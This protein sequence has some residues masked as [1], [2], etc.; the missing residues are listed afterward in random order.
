MNSTPFWG[1]DFDQLAD[2]DPE[3]A[4]IILSE[5]DRLRGGL[6]LIA[7][8]NFTSPAVLAAL[9]S[10]LSNKYAEGYPG[11]R[12]YGGCADVDRAEIDR[13]RPGE[14]PVRR[15]PRQ[16]AAAQRGQREH[17]RL[18]R[19]RHA[20]RHGPGDEPAAR[21]PPH[22]RLEGQLL[23]QV[24]RHRVVRRPPGHRAHRLRRGARPR[25]PAPPEDDHHRCHGLPE[26]H[27][28]RRLP[29]D[30]RRGRRHPDGRRRPLHRPR[31]RPGD[32]QSGAVRRRRHLH[33]P[34]GP[35]RPARRHDPVQGGAR[36]GASTRPCSR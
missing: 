8:E 3:I 2:E 15:R 21:R 6:Q 27:R 33:H 4:S 35:A 1:P 16:P 28:L 24:V 19:L 20:G 31:R 9:G 13:H 22:P 17:R 23:G 25:D 7:S 32:P 36:G 34:Q 18:R 14:G 5:L 29:R 30:R 11:K 10:T 12:Y 26:A